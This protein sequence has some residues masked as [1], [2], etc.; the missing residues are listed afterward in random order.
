VTTRGVWTVAKAD[1]A[2]EMI[3]TNMEL[4]RS[5][6][7]KGFQ[8]IFGDGESKMSGPKSVW[9]KTLERVSEGYD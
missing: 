7:K 2:R 4:S 9:S 6:G 5:K 8:F 1:A 3:R